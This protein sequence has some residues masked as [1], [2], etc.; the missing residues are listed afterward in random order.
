VIRR[1]GREVEHQGFRLFLLLRPQR[2]CFVGAQ[3]VKRLE[4][5]R[6]LFKPSL[7][8]SRL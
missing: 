8:E 5:L 7:L 1:L 2:H 6:L 4:Q 3:V